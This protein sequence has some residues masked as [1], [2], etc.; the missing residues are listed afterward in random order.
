MPELDDPFRAI[1]AELTACALEARAPTR[2]S[3]TS[4]PRRR[5]RSRRLGYFVDGRATAVIGTHTHAPTADDRVLPGG[6]AFISDVGMCG[7]YNSVLGM[8]IEEPINRFLT[9]IPRQRFEPASG[10]ATL[11]G[12]A[13]DIDDNDGA[14]AALL[15][16]E[17][18]APTWSR[19]RPRSGT[20]E[21]TPAQPSLRAQ[22]RRPL[23]RNM[24]A[25]VRRSTQ[26]T[27]PLTTSSWKPEP[28]RV[29]RLAPKSE[30]FKAQKQRDRPHAG[31]GDEPGRARRRA[32]CT[33]SRT[34]AMASEPR[35]RPLSRKMIA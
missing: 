3:S 13:V 31:P 21:P 35:N 2:S 25:A 14:G 12:L 17:D 9:K 29:N 8:D 28:K 34:L 1:D 16:V 4:T 24:I 19:P 27:T 32:R 18:W 6:T 33:S 15:G 10:P 7:D 5:A 22:A 26:L 30:D 11:S 20:T 23:T